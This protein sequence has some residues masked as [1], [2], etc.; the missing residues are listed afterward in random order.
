LIGLFFGACST[1]KDTFVNRNFHAATSKYNTLYNGNVALEQGLLMLQENYQDNFLEILPIEPLKLDVIATPGMTRDADG[2]PQE[3]EKAEEKAVKAIQ[4]HS[5]LIKSS[6]RNPQIDDAYLLLGK[7]RYYSKRFVPAL[8]AFNFVIIN[9]PNADLVNETKIWRAKTEIRLRNEERAVSRMENMLR[10]EAILEEAII[11]AAH[12]AAAMGYM[13]MQDSTQHVI[14]H[15]NKAIRT[16][17]FPEQNARNR[18]IL[19]QLYQQMNHIDSSNA[20]FKSILEL[21]KI[22]YK[23]KVHAEIAMAQNATTVEEQ[24]LAIERLKKMTNDRDNRSFLHVLN[25]QLGN[26][27]S[28]NDSVSLRYYK[29]SLVTGNPT[30]LQRELSYEKIGNVYF[31]KALF[32]TAAA[33]YDSILATN[34]TPNKKRIRRLVRKR[35]NL[36]DVILNKA[37]VKYTDSVLNLVAMSPEDRIG[38]FT[39]YTD[40]LRQDALEKEQALTDAN[41][42]NTGFSGPSR[43]R[44]SKN[45]SGTFYFYNPQT[46]GFG[47]QEFR[48]IWGNRPNED[49]WRLSNKTQIRMA[50]EETGEAIALET[51]EPEECKV[52]YYTSKIPTD[53][54][55]I[56]SLSV[57]RN[58]AYFKLGLLYKEQFKEE[59]LAIQNL[60]HLL[61]LQ[62]GDNL[63]L[64]ST[65]HLY[66]LYEN[67]DEEKATYYKNQLVNNYPNSNFTKVVVNPGEQLSSSEDTPEKIYAEVYH[68][69]EEELY[70]EVIKNTTKAIA[71]YQGMK[72]VA[73][74]ELLRAYAIGKRDGQEAFAA[75]LEFVALSYPNSD[76]GK[77]AIEVIE[78]IKEQKN[79]PN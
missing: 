39:V 72:I 69:Y 56:D 30:D 65:F 38:Y 63:E 78:I 24:A 15:L 55:E 68:N 77:K 46:V 60:E 33:Y 6:E 59:E 37:I 9:Y 19:G 28:E 32:V 73:K 44:V 49:N 74:F 22:P 79:N 29:E 76:E 51:E 62:P 47:T 2:S 70:E 34:Q 14:N 71:T 13:E 53:Q 5:M 4:K 18:F 21:K 41:L 3:F 40:S 26:L 67:I 75:A 35:S 61:T 52:S 23:Y 27:T 57:A 64:P 45:S 10:R 16:N 54:S 31:D 42:L 7:S 8:E 58:N 12:T 1:K 48:R 43:K 17:K 25:Y 66:R 36:D 11:E 50:S 20:A